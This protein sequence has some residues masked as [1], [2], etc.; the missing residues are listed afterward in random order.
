MEHLMNALY[1]PDENT[2]LVYVN[3]KILLREG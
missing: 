2:M 1:E 3:L